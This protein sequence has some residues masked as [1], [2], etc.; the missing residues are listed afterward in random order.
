MLGGAASQAT[1]QLIG[2]SNR[3]RKTLWVESLHSIVPLRSAMTRQA[4]D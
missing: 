2:E 4:G 3:A 1:A